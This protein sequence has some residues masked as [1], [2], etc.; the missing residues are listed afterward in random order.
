M[1]RLTPIAAG[2]LLFPLLALLARFVP[3]NQDEGWYLLAV[4]SVSQGLTPYTDFT[5]TQAPALPYLYQPALP[6]IRSLGLYGARLAQA[7]L[8]SVTAGLVLHAL[9]P[10]RRTEHLPPL[11]LLLAPLYLQ[12]G[13][14]VK[15]YALTGLF[16]TAAAQF[17][18][19]GPNR[20]TA[21]ASA[22][23]LGLAAA[24]R[25]PFALLMVPAALSLL[26]RRKSLGDAPWIIFTATGAAVLL[27]SL[28]PF[29]LRDPQAFFFQTLGFHTAREQAFPSAAHFAFLLRGLHTALP[30][31]AAALFLR[32][33]FRS[34]PPEEQ[35]LW[36]GIGLTTLVHF[37]APHP[38]DEY[39][40]PLYAPAAL[41]LARI[42]S[43]RNLPAS[44]LR[45]FAMLT[46]L[47]HLTSPHF[48]AWIP[49]RS[50]R[51]WHQTERA[52]DLDT[53]EYAARILNKI[54]PE[55]SVLYTPDTYLAIQ[56]GSEVPRGLE[57]GPFSFHIRGPLPGFMDW[58]G[59][60]AALAQSDFAAFTAYHFI[61]SPDITP[62]TPG[63][64]ARFRALLAED[65]FL[66][67][68]VQDFGQRRLPLEIWVR[69][70]P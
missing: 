7:L 8:L 9:A 55:N 42:A 50:D 46:L 41:L 62:F 52:T 34:L 24:T 65:F 66:H 36:S 58:S 16:L 3:L 54:V 63:E 25:Q 57:M 40:I 45:R 32:A 29:L 70:Q 43:R 44:T 33:P 23:F 19:K 60:E 30:L 1:R 11:A 2:V 17:F 53:L 61:H 21:A 49:L 5:F 6:L 14:T 67:T 13:L 31:L 38:Y 56:A 26:L 37:A 47:F 39:L 4:R 69:G 27:G 59:I 12:Y 68:T 15:T 20:K 35:A 51:I 22:L 18:L 28:G 64:E 10:K 48:H